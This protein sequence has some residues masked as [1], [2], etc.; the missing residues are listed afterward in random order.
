L[1]GNPKLDL[2]I[3]LR[4]KYLNQL[5]LSMLLSI[6]AKNS[7]LTIKFTLVVSKIRKRS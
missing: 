7:F 2:T 3:F 5:T 6:S 1:K 4:K